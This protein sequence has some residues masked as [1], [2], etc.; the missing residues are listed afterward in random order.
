MVYK[1]HEVWA[2]LPSKMR[3][4]NR[5][6]LLCGWVV[7]ISV[8]GIGAP[9]LA[10]DAVNLD[11]ALSHVFVDRAT[12]LGL[13]FVHRNGMTGALYFPEMT[14]QGGA[15]LD[16]DNDGD[17]D[18]YLIQGAQLG[19]DG[20]V[21]TAAPDAAGSD[22]GD[23]LFRNDLVAT[24]PGGPR[25]DFVDVTNQAGLASHGYGMGVATGD[26]DGD[27]WTDLYVT[28]FGPNQLWRNQGDG[29]F[30][31]VS[32]AAGVDDGLW[33]TSA[34][35]LDYDRDGNLDLYVANYVE[36]DVARNPRC[37]AT[38]S[39]RDYCGPADFPPQTD[40]LFHNLGNGRFED[41]T[42]S[43][44]IGYTP[45][46]GLGVAAADMNGD[47]WQDLFVANDGTLNH[48]WVNQGDGTF[49]D[50]ALLAG[51]ALDRHGRAEASMGVALGDVD[52][53]GDEDLFVTHLAGETN[54]MYLNQG[55]GLFED[56]TNEMGLAVGSLPYTS[57]GTALL[58]IDNDGWLDV[59]I[60]NGAVRVVESLART[61]DPYPLHQR[62]QL[63]INQEGSGFVE[64]SDQMGLEFRRSEVSR[65]A[66]IGDIDNNGRTDFLIANSNGPA[67]LLVN[68]DQSGQNWIGFA[69][70]QDPGHGGNLDTTVEI[71]PTDRPSRWRWV[72]TDGSYCS[73]SD[74]R[75]RAGL[76]E[77]DVVDS[78]KV[79]QTG[80]AKR[81]WRRLPAGKYYVAAPA[82]L[83]I[84]GPK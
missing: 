77:A 44:L 19:D 81:E 7:V 35:F 80:V 59:L 62:N 41:R 70:S 74:P 13:D 43:A 8:Q 84:Q 6:L 9:L 10:A 12:E 76:G 73:A 78:L 32:K 39:R 21:V 26:F 58:D 28:N 48:L 20:K 69:L 14:G 46:P 55:A 75:V 22:L 67:R 11:P 51:V 34:T 5:L 66:V 24:E 56:R 3:I 4:Q 52:G 15:M 72:R 83:S 79:T 57:F 38:S 37:Y 50:D 68:S 54:T 29:T 47:G 36:F 53:D 23:R 2:R 25:P 30:A 33:G 27:G 45:A 1:T 49:R 16:F 63:Y 42:A 31:D 82:G 64:I 61:G 18:I 40:R 65:G 17:L 60:V 71:S